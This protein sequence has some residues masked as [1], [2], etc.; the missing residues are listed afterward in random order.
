MCPH[1]CALGLQ[2]YRGAKKG[3]LHG[4]ETVTI[5]T[6]YAG[7]NKTPSEV[8]QARSEAEREKNKQVKPTPTKKGQKRKVPG[9]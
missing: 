3:E 9:V 4:L 5:A 1:G 7:G 8:A 6:K 2:A